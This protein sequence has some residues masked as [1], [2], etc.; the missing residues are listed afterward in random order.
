ME[1]ECYY[2]DQTRLEKISN[3]LIESSYSPKGTTLPL[4]P[5]CV[6][7]QKTFSFLFSPV[8]L[9]VFSTAVH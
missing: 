8:S 9:V 1:V 2:I 3:R 4:G 6:P 5:L 7:F